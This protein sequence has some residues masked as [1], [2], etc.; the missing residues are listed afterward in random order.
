MGAVLLQVQGIQAVNLNEAATHESATFWGLGH[1]CSGS[2]SGTPQC[3]VPPPAAAQDTMGYW[4][5]GGVGISTLDV[6]TIVAEYTVWDSGGQVP[7]TN[8]YASMP[9]S[10][11]QILYLT[12]GGVVGA[13]RA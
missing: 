7:Y 6:A 2:L 11:Y 3:I 1:Y 5:Y 12:E 13:T 10:S 4:T 8:A 9:L